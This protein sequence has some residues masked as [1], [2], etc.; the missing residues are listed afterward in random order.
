M[1]PKNFGGIEMRLLSFAVKSYRSLN[2][3]RKITLGQKAVIVGPNNE[4]KSNLINALALAMRIISEYRVSRRS[5][6]VRSN[7]LSYDWERDYPIDL[8]ESQPNGKTEVTLEFSLSPDEIADFRKTIKS[9][10][11]GSLPLTVYLDNNNKFEIKVRKKGPGGN[12][13]TKKSDIIA[14]FVSD[15]LNFE[16]IPTIRTATSAKSIVDA[17]VARELSVLQ[18]R[19][20]YKQALAVLES[21]QRPVLKQLSDG[22]MDTLVKFLPS[23]RSVS[24]EMPSDI[25]SRGL[26]RGCEIIVDD[27]LATPL[28]QKGDGVQSLAA[29]ALMRHA[30][31]TSASGRNL[32]IAIEEPESHL[33]PG[34]MHEIRD[35]VSDLA[36][37]HQV[38]ITTHN[39]LFVDRS[40]I[41]RNIIVVNNQA[42]AATSMEQLRETLGVRASD[43]LRNAEMVLL[44]E[45]AD[46]KLA[47]GALLKQRSQICKNALASG[48]LVIESLGGGTNLPYQASLYVSALYKVMAFVDDDNAGH[49]GA[50]ATLAAGFISSADIVFSCVQGKPEAEIEDMYDVAIYRDLIYTDYGP[51]LDHPK[52]KGKG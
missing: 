26:R 12:T 30:S 45:G 2:S 20:D 14:L 38:I 22:I 13:L 28:E 21:L 29:L 43:N 50:D 27:G 16:H 37:L 7:L 3:A 51:S 11:N 17:L 44:V 36:K 9:N 39:P 31:E 46:D 41:S 47:I 1:P 32:I 25:G 23:V 52:F 34:A 18:E 15:R 42:R 35:V 10:L 48:G 49:R 19:E 8:Q 33:H 40:D 5:R 4:G 24:V 6:V